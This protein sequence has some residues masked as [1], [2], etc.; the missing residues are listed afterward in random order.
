MCCNYSAFMDK[1]LVVKNA[2]LF[3][4]DVSLHEKSV[5]LS[6]E[7]GNLNNIE[8]RK[9]NDYCILTCL[10]SV[11]VILRSNTLIKPRLNDSR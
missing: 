10:S 5:Q 7:R 9:S 2:I 8:N 1:Q 6:D 4:T 11:L 3:R